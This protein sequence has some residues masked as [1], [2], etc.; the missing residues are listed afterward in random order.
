VANSTLPIQCLFKS[1]RIRLSAFVYGSPGF[2]SPALHQHNA[3][4]MPT[5]ATKTSI[6]AV[7]VEVKELASFQ[8][9]RP[10]PV[11]RMRTVV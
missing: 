4:V 8:P 5:I 10:E 2:D 6:T 7:T 11:H 1:E 9:G 3:Y